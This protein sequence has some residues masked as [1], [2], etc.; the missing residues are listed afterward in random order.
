[1]LERALSIRVKVFGPDHPHTAESLHNLASLWQAQGDH[2]TARPLFERALTINEKTIGP[3]HQRTNQT[4]SKLA[5]LRLSQGAALEALAMAETALAAHE[6]VLG[7]DHP[8]TKGSALVTAGA[9][10]AL[11]RGDEAAAVRAR[12]GIGDGQS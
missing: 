10:D 4:R 1:M 2:E 3:E 6:R 7:A 12:Y 9:L 11:G 8:W 5:R